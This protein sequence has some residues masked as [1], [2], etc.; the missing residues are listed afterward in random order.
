MNSRIINM[1]ITFSILM[2]AILNSKK[3]V[4]TLLSY[5]VV[6]WGD[7]RYSGDASSVDLNDTADI[8]C[9]GEVCVARKNDGTAVAWGDD[10]FGG[11]ASSVNLTDVDDIMCEGH[12]CVVHKNDGTA[13]A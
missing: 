12:A 5:S 4:K 7:D 3:S 11:D 9:G 13:V 2:R 6:V 10:M 1:F 8:M